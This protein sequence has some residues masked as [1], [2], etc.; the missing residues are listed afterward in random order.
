MNVLEFQDISVIYQN[1]K[2]AVHNVSFTVPEHSIV[3]VV[4]E[5]GSGKI[6]FNTGRPW[7]FCPQAAA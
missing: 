1:G 3:A 4:G 2:T 6:H 5:S 7:G